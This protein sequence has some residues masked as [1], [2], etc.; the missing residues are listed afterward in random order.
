MQLPSITSTRAA[1]ANDPITSVASRPHP[2]SPECFSPPPSPS[3]REGMEVGVGGG[4]LL[5]SAGEGRG[6]G[7]RGPSHQTILRICALHCLSAVFFFFFLHSQPNGAWFPRSRAPAH[8]PTQRAGGEPDF[9]AG[10][11]DGA[12]RSDRLSDFRGSDPP[13]PT[14][15]PPFQRSPLWPPGPA[16]LG[17]LLQDHGDYWDSL[18]VASW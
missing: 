8:L 14:A 17:R 13:S 12:P 18:L 9:N 2:P 10:A 4:G 5:M 11:A 3:R 15:L 7:P 6:G 1:V 16:A